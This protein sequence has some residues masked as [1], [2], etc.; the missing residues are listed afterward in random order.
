ML[1]AD[2]VGFFLNE[3]ATYCAPSTIRIYRLIL[4][5]FT[6]NCNIPDLAAI[7]EPHIIEYIRTLRGQTAAHTGTLVTT[8]W[9]SDQWRVIN[10]FFR[11][12]ARQHWVN[13]NPAQYVKTPKVQNHRQPLEE[14]Q[15]VGLLHYL[16]SSTEA[17]IERDRAL[18]FFALDTGAR[19]GELVSLDTGRVLLEQRAAILTGKGDKHRRVGYSARTQIHLSTYLDVRKEQTHEKFFL[20]RHGKPLTYAGIRQISRR[21]EKKVGF[22][23]YL[24]QLRRTYA[25][26]FALSGGQLPLLQVSMGHSNMHTT[27]QYAQ[28]AL[29][30]AAVA[31][32]QKHSLVANL[33][34]SFPKDKLVA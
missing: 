30:A 11:Y 19:A 9:V 18:F 29:E 28:Q 4:A 17:L 1:T 21:L 5:Q 33:A 23:F 13:E 22:H 15:I 24:H 20:N 27:L 34:D 12:C 26:Q 16:E 10:T 14:T 25:V 7:T 6:E 8:Q 2:A 32:M 31:E 3:R